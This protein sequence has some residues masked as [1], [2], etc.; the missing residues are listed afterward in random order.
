MPLDEREVHIWYAA[1]DVPPDPATLSRFRDW[2]SPEETD[3]Y[4]HNEIRK[5][6]DIVK[7]ANLKID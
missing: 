4:L 3:R 1:T 7:K 5:W 2:L 6:A